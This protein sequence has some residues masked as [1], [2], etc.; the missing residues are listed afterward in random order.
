MTQHIVT[1]EGYKLYFNE[2]T[3]LKGLKAGYQ[4]WHAGSKDITEFVNRIGLQDYFKHGYTL[5]YVLNNGPSPTVKGNVY[6][7]MLFKLGEEWHESDHE[8]PALQAPGRGTG[9]GLWSG[10]DTN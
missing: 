1:I 7:A 4:I 6:V 3:S 2:V 10:M 8:W 5:R 9:V